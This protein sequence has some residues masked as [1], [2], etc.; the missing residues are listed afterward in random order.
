VAKLK[1]EFLQHYYDANGVPARVNAL[2]HFPLANRVGALLPGVANRLLAGKASSAV[3]KK[4]LGI[5]PERSIPPLSS[6]TLLAWHQAVGARREGIA[7]LRPQRQP[8]LFFAD[9]FTNYLDAHIGQDA[10]RLLW[11]LGYSTEVPAV[12][13]SGRT[14][15]SKGLVKKAREYARR[16]VALLAGYAR[17]GYA[18]VG[19]EPSTLLTLRDE[20]PELVPAHQRADARALAGAA[21]L[22]DE[23]AAGAIERGEWL[24]SDFDEQ[25]RTIHYHGHCFQKALSSTRHS[26]K[27]LGFPLRHQVREIPSGCCGMAGFF[28]YE[29]EH[30]ELSMKIGELVLLPAARKAPADHLLAAIGNSCR[31]QIRDGAAREALHTAEILWQ[32]VRK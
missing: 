23:F 24:K 17:N 4:A 7:P 32:A 2:A 14:F 26:I 6:P 27:A 19:V 30:Y 25:E 10:L 1:A 11:R 16:N 31:H 22:F 20:Y 9:E 12:E 18:I 29:A 15:L 28:G 8:V 13:L 21:L 3:F 5:A